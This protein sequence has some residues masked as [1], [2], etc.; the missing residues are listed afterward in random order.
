MI[1]RRNTTQRRILLE[2]IRSSR[3]HPTAAELYDAVRDRLPHIS[4]GTVYRNLDLLT[5]AGEIRRLG[6]AGQE[7]R[8]DGVTETHSHL[9]CRICGR[10]EDAAE[11]SDVSVQSQIASSSGWLLSGPRVEFEGICPDCLMTDRHPSE[12]TNLNL[13]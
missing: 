8:F 6:G 11:A 3:R 1:A 10:I 13:R 9:R 12:S 2:E 4:L 5:E 7:A